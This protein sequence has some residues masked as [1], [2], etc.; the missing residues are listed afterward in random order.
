[1]WLI[2]INFILVVGSAVY[3]AWAVRRRR[4]QAT[5]HLKLITILTSSVAIRELLE[6]V[7]TE[8]QIAANASRVFFF[9]YKPDGHFVSSGTKDHLRP[10]VSDCM[11]LESYFYRT[12]RT[13]ARAHSL[14][15]EAEIRRLLKSYRVDFV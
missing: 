8:V 1:M 11:L 2:V 3:L 15:D 7:S 10:T 5:F 6:R 4:R 13:S 12:N 14:H 9:V